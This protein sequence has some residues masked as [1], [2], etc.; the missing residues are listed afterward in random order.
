MAMKRK[1]FLQEFKQETRRAPKTKAKKL[2]L[3]YRKHSKLSVLNLAYTTYRHATSKQ[4]KSIAKPS[5]QKK[6]KSRESEIQTRRRKAVRGQVDRIKDKS[7]RESKERGKER[8]GGER[9]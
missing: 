2:R 1:R 7:A 9:S 6:E 4:A 8:G 3:P 5:Q